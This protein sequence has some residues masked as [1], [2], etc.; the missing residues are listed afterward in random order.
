MRLEIRALKLEG[1][2]LE[3]CGGWQRQAKE[4]LC[5]G[6]RE[7]T[8][9][10][11]VLLIPQTQHVIS[12]TLFWL[13]ILVYPQFCGRGVLGTVQTHLQPESRS[14]IACS[15]STVP[16]FHLQHSSLQVL[17]HAEQEV[18]LC[19]QESCSMKIKWGMPKTME[20][21]GLKSGNEI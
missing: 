21:I 7:R 19:W 2:K 9:R 16:G 4:H 3:K 13:F 1:P 15:P 8:G 18:L 14:Q 6:F 17:T 10:I 5:G 20:G 11:A 12:I